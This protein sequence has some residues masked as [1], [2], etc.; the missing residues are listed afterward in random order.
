M[1]SSLS[2][3]LTGTSRKTPGPWLKYYVIVEERYVNIVQVDEKTITGISVRTT[4][5]NETNPETSQIGALY[6]RFDETVPVDYKNGARVY[7][8]YYNYE[9]DASGEFSVL[10]GSDQIN[11]SV[12]S[13]LEQ[14]TIPGGK[15][16]VFEAA[17]EMP[18]VVIDTWSKIW[19][20]FSTENV[21]YQRA[22]T[23]DF[24]FYKNQNEIEIYIAVK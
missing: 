7:G 1:S 16:M 17:G 15:Y 23:T 24:E 2:L 3:S 8:V 22:Y 10:A 19:D 12:V 20:Y 9:S 5:A 21:P 14:V 11:E 18:Q 13:T 4:N 6:Q